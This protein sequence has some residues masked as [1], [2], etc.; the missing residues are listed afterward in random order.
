VCWGGC[1]KRH[2]DGSG[3]DAEGRF[4]RTNLPR[5]IAS[6]VGHELAGQQ[7]FSEADQF[8]PWHHS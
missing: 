5:M 1:P 6:G 7:A 8:R 2:L 3:T 4:W